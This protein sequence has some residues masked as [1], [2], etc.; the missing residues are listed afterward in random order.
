MGNSNREMGAYIGMHHV[1]RA[2]SK[3]RMREGTLRVLGNTR[4]SGVVNTVCSLATWLCKYFWMHIHLSILAFT[5]YSKSSR[6]IKAEIVTLTLGK[7]GW[8]ET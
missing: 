5:L 2:R 3:G 1:V 8:P 4:F 6:P 7:E